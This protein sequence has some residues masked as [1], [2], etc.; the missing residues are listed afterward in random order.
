MRKYWLIRVFGNHTVAVDAG[1]V[2]RCEN[3]RNSRV[4]GN[5][6]VQISEMKLGTGIR[7]TDHTQA[8]SVRWSLICAEDFRAVDF[9]SAVE[10]N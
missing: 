7:G 1:N 8:K 10:P 2:L 6:F 5:E 3:Q 9:F 4:S